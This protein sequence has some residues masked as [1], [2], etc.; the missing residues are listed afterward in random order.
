MPM[1]LLSLEANSGALADGGGRLSDEARQP[2]TNKLQR[3]LQA[4]SVRGGESQR[5]LDRRRRTP[6]RID[7]EILLPA[8]RCRCRTWWRRR[9]RRHAGLS[10]RPA[11]V[12]CLPRSGVCARAPPSFCLLSPRVI[13]IHQPFAHLPLAVDS[14]SPLGRDPPLLSTCLLWPT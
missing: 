3:I 8:C 6:K 10:L 5:G 2:R 12:G 9:P 13:L 7:G 11:H 1:L 14:P 4:A